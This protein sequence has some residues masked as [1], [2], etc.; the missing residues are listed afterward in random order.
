MESSNT[1]NSKPTELTSQ[2]NKNKIQIKMME[3]KILPSLS[4]KNAA[5]GE[6]KHST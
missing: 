3:K 6:F 4:E 1:A 2:R 5:R